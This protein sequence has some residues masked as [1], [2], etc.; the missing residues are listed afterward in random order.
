M[1][2]VIEHVHYSEKFNY[3]IIAN[4]AEIFIP[5]KNYPPYTTCTMYIYLLIFKIIKFLLY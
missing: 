4:F 1:T 5:Q 3:D 2:Q